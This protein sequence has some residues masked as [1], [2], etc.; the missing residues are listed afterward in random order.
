MPSSPANTVVP[1]KKRR[2]LSKRHSNDRDNSEEDD[3]DCNDNNSG[4]NNGDNN[5]GCIDTGED[6]F[7]QRQSKRCKQGGDDSYASKPDMVVDSVLKGKP[8]RR[9]VDSS[10]SE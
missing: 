6:D 1:N 5:D 3:R 8:R 7:I 9:I 4:D 2:H 10:D